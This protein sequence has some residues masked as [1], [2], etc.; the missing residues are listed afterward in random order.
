MEPA[1]P[2]EAQQ[3]VYIEQ[4]IREKASQEKENEEIMKTEA[5]KNAQAK[6]KEVEEIL[7]N[8]VNTLNLFFQQAAVEY[9]N[10]VCIFFSFSSS[11]LFLPRNG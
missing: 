6:M 2:T 8:R 10:T 5:V 4:K 7:N 11:N 9:W 1:T 3:R